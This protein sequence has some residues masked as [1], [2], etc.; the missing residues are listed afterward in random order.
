MAGDQLSAN[1]FETGFCGGRVPWSTDSF[2]R[3]TVSTNSRIAHSM[4]QEN[5]EGAKPRRWPLES[6]ERFMSKQ[7]VSFLIC[8]VHPG[9]GIPPEW[10]WTTRQTKQ[11]PV[12][13]RLGKDAKI[14]PQVP[15]PDAWT[16]ETGLLANE[17]D[18]VILRKR[19]RRQARRPRSRLEEE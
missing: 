19:R 16:G 9:S 18:C 15:S 17:P 10:S 3:I 1:I 12:A 4:D 8:R 11:K 6:A 13:C 2:E 7:S 14:Q 5:K